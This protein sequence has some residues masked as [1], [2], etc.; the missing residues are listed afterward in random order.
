MSRGLSWADAAAGLGALPTYPRDYWA[1]EAQA[2]AASQMPGGA[3]QIPMEPGLSGIVRRIGDVRSII[4]DLHVV[5]DHACGARPP[6]GDNAPRCQPSGVLDQIEEELNALHS[7]AFSVLRR[8][9]RL[10]SG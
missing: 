3:V 10:G 1:N 9:Q 5:A 6:A 4:A 7:E 2:Q 8:L